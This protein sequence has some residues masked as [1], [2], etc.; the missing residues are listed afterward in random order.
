[1]EDGILKFDFEDG[2]IVGVSTNAALEL[3]Y[4]RLFKSAQAELQAGASIDVGIRLLIFGCFWLEAVCSQTLRD[5]L[6]ASVTP[7]T[8]G[9][10]LWDANKR[11]S[12][13]DK[14]LILLAST[15]NPDLENGK[16]L[17]VDLK[18]VFDLRNRLAHFKDDDTPVTKLELEDIDKY[19]DP[20]LNA[21]LRSALARGHAQTIMDG[22]SLLEK[23]RRVHFG[24][25]ED[26]SVRLG[27]EQ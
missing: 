26:L 5:V 20:E 7:K 9:K 12:F 4:G 8:L 17:M 14:L 1:M 21:Q 22:M 13:L 24:I 6:S 15:K 16:T 23:T 19:P 10:A 3:A 2:E 11:A 27:K 25:R 18:K